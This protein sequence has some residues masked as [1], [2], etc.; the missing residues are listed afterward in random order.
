LPGTTIVR[1]KSDAQR[2][3]EILYAQDSKV[4]AWD[5]ETYAIDPKIES[6]VGKG[7]ILCATAFCG[8]EM[9]F[10]NGPRLFIDNYA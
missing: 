6:P 5:T 3:L 2:A 10:G 8:P 9:N 1:S 4:C 7:K